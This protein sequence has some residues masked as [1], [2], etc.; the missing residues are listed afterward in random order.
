MKKILFTIPA[1]NGGGMGRAVVNYATEFSKLGFQVG[2]FLLTS[3]KIQKYDIPES[4]KVY[5]GVGDFYLK[6]NFFSSLY[7]LRKLCRKENYNYVLSFS[8]MHSCYVIMALTGIDL[9]VFVFHR[10]NPYVVYG[11]I[12]DLLNR[13]FFPKSAGLV[14]Q[15]QT[16][17]DF[18]ATKYKHP[19][20]IIVPNPV[21]KIIANRNQNRENIIVSVSRLIKDK[22]YDIL[23]DIF[24]DICKRGNKEW[25]LQIVGDGECRE[26]LD[27]QIKKRGMEDYITLFGFQKD[28][29]YF[30][31]KAS[32]FAFASKSEGFPNALLEAMCSGLACISFDCPT[33]PSEMIINGQNGFLIRLEDK[34]TYCEKLEQLMRDQE[35]REK[36]STEALKLQNR[37]DSRLIIENFISKI[38][39]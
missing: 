4:I 22:G 2:I 13:I 8:G 39:K 23:I 28:V 32:I 16:A 7:R 26:M 1:I 29:D 19:N 25:K 33:G 11:K 24:A 21:R 15:T 6:I 14:V 10:A 18:F 17:M 37:Y 31:S 35:L 30:L 5:S 12:N 38:I 36:F 27:L 20:I 3:K 34:E 9:K